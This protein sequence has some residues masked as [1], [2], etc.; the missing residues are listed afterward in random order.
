MLVSKAA[1]RDLKRLHKTL[2]KKQFARLDSKIQSL[3]NNP[4]P[5]GCE[6][7]EGMLNAYRVRDGNY[8]IIYV[9]DDDAKEVKV[10]RVRDRKDV[11]RH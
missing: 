7:M 4:R 5:P 9:V 1:R 11:Y 6:D 2:S 3:A 8:R 10:G